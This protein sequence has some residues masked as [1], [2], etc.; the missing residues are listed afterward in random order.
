MLSE[1]PNPLRNPPGVR[2]GP[3]IIPQ[4]PST[5]LHHNLRIAFSQCYRI[6]TFDFVLGVLPHKT[7]SQVCDDEESEQMILLGSVK[8]THY[9]TDILPNRYI[10]PIQVVH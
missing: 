1:E 9:Q 4:L 10:S 6:A 7:G 5:Y 3:S 8:L 2:L